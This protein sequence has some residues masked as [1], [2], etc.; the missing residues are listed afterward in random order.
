MEIQLRDN[1]IIRKKIIVREGGCCD[2]L[3]GARLLCGVLDVMGIMRCLGRGRCDVL[4]SELGHVNMNEFLADRSNFLGLGKFDSGRAAFLLL[5]GNRG[6][7]RS[8]DRR[9]DLG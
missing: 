9:R 2:V 8:K 5:A 3:P 1:E 6:A 7:I 4:E